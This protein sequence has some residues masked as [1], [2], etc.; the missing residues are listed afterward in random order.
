MIRELS[1]TQL[2]VSIDESLYYVFWYDV[3]E[4]R[5]RATPIR[6]FFNGEQRERPRIVPL[7]GVLR[8]ECIYIQ[9]VLKTNKHFPSVAHD[10]TKLL[11]PTGSSALG[12]NSYTFAGEIVASD[13]Y[14]Y[15]NTPRDWAMEFVVDCG[16]PL[17]FRREYDPGWGRCFENE[18]RDGVYVEGLI[19]LSVSPFG[20]LGLHQE[21]SGTVRDVKVLDLDPAS[22]NFGQVAVVPFGH[23]LVVDPDTVSQETVFATVAI[24]DCGSLAYSPFSAR[25]EECPIPNYPGITLTEPGVKIVELNP[26]INMDGP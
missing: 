15:K 9:P 18:V 5:M 14:A 4:D 22:A 25:S 1:V 10:G 16:A 21:V 26:P 23:K 13:K 7:Q 20:R 2:T 3:P 17:C 11:Q 12:P 24:E 6:R 8:A 19:R